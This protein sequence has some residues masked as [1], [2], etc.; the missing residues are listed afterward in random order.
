MTAQVLFYFSHR[1]FPMLAETKVKVAARG[2]A[3]DDVLY[4][5]HVSQVTGKGSKSQ[6]YSAFNDFALVLPNVR[7]DLQNIFFG[8]FVCVERIR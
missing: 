6:P 4:D 2:N 8:K 3:C 1:L 5:Q 7:H